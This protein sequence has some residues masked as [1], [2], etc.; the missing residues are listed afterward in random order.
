MLE[1]RAE[2]LVEA[3]LALRV[4]DRCHDLDAPTQIAGRQSA[5]PM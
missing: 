2:D 5:E 4:S 3:A 1:I